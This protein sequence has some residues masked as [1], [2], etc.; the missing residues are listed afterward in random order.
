MY[1]T[2]ERHFVWRP[3]LRGNYAVEDFIPQPFIYNIFA[4]VAETW[5][6]IWRIQ[7]RKSSSGEAWLSRS[8]E[9]NK[10]HYIQVCAGLIA[11]AS[12]GSWG[13]SSI[14]LYCDYSTC[15]SGIHSPLTFAKFSQF[16][17]LGVTWKLTYFS[18]LFLPPSDPPAI[19]PWFF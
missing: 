14:Q 9:R 10:D 13:S 2:T 7:T 5:K 19:A 18:Q 6:R 3:F 15:V 16:L 8:V 11:W 12:C 4:D 17:L 1:Q